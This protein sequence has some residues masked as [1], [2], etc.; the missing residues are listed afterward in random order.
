MPFV[1]AIHSPDGV[2]RDVTLK[3]GETSIGRDPSSQLVLEGRGVSRRH[4]KFVVTGDQLTIVDLGSTYGTRVND[5][6]T[7]RRE[8]SPGDRLTV[9]MHQLEIKL[10][11]VGS[12]FDISELAERGSPPYFSEDVTQDP[13]FA[14]LGQT[15]AVGE[16]DE[17]NRKTLQL[18]RS[19]INFVLDNPDEQGQ[20]VKVLSKRQSDLMQAVQRLEAT[21]G[22]LEEF[23]TPTAELQQAADYQALLLMY[24]VSAELAAATDLDSFLAPTADLVMEAVSANT[25]V[26]LLLDGD[27]LVPRVIRHRGALH[28]GEV[29]VSRGILDLVLAEGETVVS[30]DVGHDERIQTGH[31][32]T[33]YNIRSVVAAP[34]MV[35]GEVKGV[36]YLNRSGPIPFSSAD[37]DLV[38]AL[39]SLMASG[40]EQSRLKEDYASETLRRRA[41]ERFH[42]PEVVDRIFRTGGQVG[43]LEEHQATALVCDISGFHALTERLG[44]REIAQ[45]LHEYY[46]TIYEKVFD[47]GGSLVK[48]HDG[49]AL[50]LFGAPESSDRDAVWAVEAGLALCT[51]FSSLKMLWPEAN[52]LSLCCALDSGSV[53]AGLVGSVDRHEYVA[54]GSPIVTTAAVAAQTNETALIVTE[55]TWAELPQMRY[56]VK[57]V[58]LLPDQRIYQLTEA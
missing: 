3:D 35:R 33:L 25:V 38:A 19:A 52:T 6:P 30:N 50:A 29:P 48:L 39:G 55:R 12:S 1:L 43:M 41:L 20:A 2:L 5:V 42:P 51:E 57:E 21:T 54:L 26:V 4:A 49:W 14:E 18:D 13:Q 47:N 53:V 10:A 56:R 22:N 31:S 16:D 44:P 7:M 32:L 27:E 15:P 23:K 24:K 8:L 34:L 58:D 46:E 9:G 11:T 36:L 37:G 28:P 17:D 45:I 40:I